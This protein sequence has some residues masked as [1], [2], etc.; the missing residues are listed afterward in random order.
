VPTLNLVPFAPSGWD[1][2]IVSIF[3]F[4]R[5]RCPWVAINV[6]ALLAQ[7]WSC[8]SCGHHPARFDCP[9]S[10]AEAAK[11]QK[12]HQACLDLAKDNPSIVCR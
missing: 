8:P 10:V 2:P 7:I 1:S 4:R 11:K 3:G 5:Y 9:A 12:Q 6:W